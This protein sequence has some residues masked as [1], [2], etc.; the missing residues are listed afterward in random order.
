M[1]LWISERVRLFQRRFAS[2]ET[3]FRSKFCNS[4]SSQKCELVGQNNFLLSLL[5]NRQVQRNKNHQIADSKSAEMGSSLKNRNR[6]LLPDAQKK[7][8]GVPVLGLI[9]RMCHSLIFLQE[10]PNRFCDW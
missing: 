10:S 4:I 1:T 5:C 9:S 2:S 3:I 6:I 8:Q 7:A